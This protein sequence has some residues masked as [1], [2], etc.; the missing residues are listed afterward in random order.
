MATIVGL[1][2]NGTT[3][4]RDGDLI[5]TDGSGNPYPFGA[6]NTAFPLHYRVIDSSGNVDPAQDSSGN[7]IVSC[8][9]G[10]TACFTEGG[11]FVAEPTAD[12]TIAHGAN[13]PLWVKQPA[14]GSGIVKLSVSVPAWVT[15]TRCPTLGTLTPTAGDA[16]VT[17]AFADIALGAQGYYE[18][19]R[20]TDSG[21]TAN[22]VH[23]TTTL[24]DGS[25]SY[26]NNAANGNAP[27]N[28]TLYYYRGRGVDYRGVGAWSATASA[29]PSAEPSQVTISLL[30][31]MI[32]ATS[33]TSNFQNTDPYVGDGSGATSN[34]ERIL[35]KPDT[36]DGDWATLSGKTITAVKLRFYC[37]TAYKTSGMS[38]PQNAS[39]YRLKRD[40]NH[41]QA[42][43]NVYTTGNGW[44]TAGADNTA[45]DREATPDATVAL[46]AA[47]GSTNPNTYTGYEWE[48]TG[49]NW[50]TTTLAN[51]WIMISV[52]EGSGT[53][54]AFFHMFND[55]ANAANKPEMLVTYTG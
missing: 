29:T 5:S 6:L 20:A 40:A 3:G 23:L 47:T 45:T 39:I 30:T 55:D 9:S 50:T 32:V 21:F 51:G 52:A 15:G 49:L 27:S 17:L 54:S 41:A 43:W 37:N 48:A 53:T 46:A 31:T 8:G 36:T 11:S 35:I 1:F 26:V 25:T 16:S 34:K 12:A 13:Q 24:A 10:A 38:S 22:L 28:G 14:G 42:T 19:D 18:I 33:A 44:G 2:E 4:A 7:L